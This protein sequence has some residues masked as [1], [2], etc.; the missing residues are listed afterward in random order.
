MEEH[1][2]HSTESDGDVEV[3]GDPEG[4]S[5]LGTY[6]LDYTNIVASFPGSLGGGEES[7]VTTACACVTALTNKTL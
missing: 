4:D 3:D 6:A 2:G 5:D 7:L 1:T